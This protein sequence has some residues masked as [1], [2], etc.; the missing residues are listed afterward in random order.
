MCAIEITPAI[1][2]ERLLLR[3]PVIHDAERLTQ[4]AGDIGVAGMVSSMPHPYTRDDAEDWLSKQVV[5]DWDRNATF[6]IEHHAFG[7]VGMIGL[8]H[9]N[10]DRPELGYWLGRP[11]WNRGYATEALT[12]ALRWMRFDW[13][14]NVVWAGHFADNRASG[15]VLVKAGFLYTGDVEVRRSAAREGAGVRTRMMVWLA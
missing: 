15:Q 6:A 14:R 13:R 7:L 1:S 3:G 4:F 5:A 12:A 2:T 9:R 10:G 8:T 11:F